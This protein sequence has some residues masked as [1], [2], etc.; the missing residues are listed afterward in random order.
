[1][2]DTPEYKLVTANDPAELS[3]QVT[4]LMAQRW[5]PAR[6]PVISGSPPTYAQAMIREPLEPPKM[7]RADEEIVRRA[8]SILGSRTSDAKR[9]SSRRN[10][11]RPRK[12]RAEEQ[13]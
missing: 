10:A 7:R 6:D 13:C 11:H 4:E 1:V 2:A 5:R 3:K 12:K 9:A 8:M